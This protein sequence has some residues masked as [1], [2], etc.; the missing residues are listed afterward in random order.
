ML[1]WSLGA[2]IR[3]VVWGISPSKAVT[4][5]QILPLS[6]RCLPASL[7]KKNADL[8][9]TSLIWSYSASLMSTIGFL[10][11]LP[12]VLMAMSGRP[13]ASTTSANSFSMAPARVRSAWNATAW[14]PAALIAAIVASAS[15]FVES[16]L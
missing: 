8:A 12:T 15:A 9:L 4:S 14:A 11:T 5:M 7:R 16:L 2:R 1:H 3:G 10:S 6:L 13:M